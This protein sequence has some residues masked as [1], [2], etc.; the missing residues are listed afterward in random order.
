MA[1][2]RLFKYDGAL[3]ELAYT[4]RHVQDAWQVH[5]GAIPVAGDHELQDRAEYGE[6]QQAI[7]H[8]KNVL[9]TMVRRRDELSDALLLVERP[10]ME[11]ALDQRGPGPEEGDERPPQR[12]YQLEKDEH[13]DAAEG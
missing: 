9:R 11:A 6:I 7:T 4:L 8:C 2:E 3:R 12:G 10:R 1:T 13:G 5:V